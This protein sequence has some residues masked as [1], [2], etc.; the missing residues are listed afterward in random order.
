[1]DYRILL[2]AAVGLVFVAFGGF[3]FALSSRL[4]EPAGVAKGCA[5]SRFAA[6]LCAARSGADGDG[7]ATERTGGAAG[8]C[9]RLLSAR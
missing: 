9:G 5:V 2:A 1:M 4:H 7:A 8:S 6:W 3:F